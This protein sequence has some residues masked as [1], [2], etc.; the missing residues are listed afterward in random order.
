MT[1]SKTQRERY[2]RN[3][4]LPEIG[5]KGQEKLLQSKILIVGTG[6]LGSPAALYLAAAG[7]GTLGLADGDKV[8]CSNLQRQILHTTETI[9]TPKVSSAAERIRALNPDTRLTLHP[10][11][12]N[13]ANAVELIA[14]YDFIIDATD[15]YHAKLLIAKA[16]AKA[17]KAY[18]HAGIR[19]FHGQTMTVDPGKTACY[20][21]IFN[22]TGTT[23]TS[24]PEGPL[25]ALPGVI[26]AIQATEAIKYLLSIGTPL[27]N[28][29]LTYDA[30][31]MH[32]RKIPVQRDPLCP[33]CGE[34]GDRKRVGNGK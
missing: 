19:H 1:L 25:G 29:I 8:D 32:V 28:T 31:A 5:E 16:C 13:E 27:F 7:T 12:I 21:C 17:G 20:A 34:S 14:R 11:H 4:S 33:I 18:S 9:G 3:L 10:Y 30:L 6:G 23:E 24:H 22:E 26:G 15:S 2:A